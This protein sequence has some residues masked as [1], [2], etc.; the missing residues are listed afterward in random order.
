MQNKSIKKPIIVLSVILC[1]IISASAQNK[2]FISIWGAGGYAAMLDNVE[3]TNPALGGGGSVGFGYELQRRNFIFNVGVEGNYE[4]T[5]NDIKN[6]TT[7]IDMVDTEGDPFV[8]NCLFN[9]R[10]DANQLA[11]VNVPVMVGAQFGKFY[12]LVGG[13]VG[14]NLYGKGEAASDMT[15]TGTYPQFIGVFENM[16]NHSFTSSYYSS[17]SGVS[18]KPNAAA[19]CE[20]GFRLGGHSNETGFDVPKHKTQYR[21]GVFADYGITNMHKNVSNGDLLT[22]APGT[23]GL[24]ITLNNVY[25]SNLAMDKKIN[26]LFVGVKFTILFKLPEP[27]MCV[28]CSDY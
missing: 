13:K 26:N 5:V 28:I 15:A 8:Y 23:T 7:N 9:N 17:Q 19:S 22:C 16:P 1:S 25:I 3:E 10:K 18:F 2:H 24:D 11:N 20:L 4:K 6:T 27:G 21:L 12:F 14:F